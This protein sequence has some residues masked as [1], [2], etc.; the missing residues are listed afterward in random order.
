MD[1]RTLVQ[2]VG[3]SVVLAVLAYLFY[4]GSNG[5]SK[6]EKRRGFGGDAIFACICGIAAVVVPVVVYVVMSARAS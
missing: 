5:R 1:T 2:T 4:A 3:C 6:A